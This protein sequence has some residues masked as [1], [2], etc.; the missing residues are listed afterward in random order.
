M[1][2]EFCLPLQLSRSVAVI[3]KLGKFSFRTWLSS[4]FATP[5]KFCPKTIERLTQKKFA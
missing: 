3:L 5:P 2:T 4:T 1:A